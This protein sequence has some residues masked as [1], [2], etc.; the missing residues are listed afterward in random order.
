MKRMSTMVF[1]AIAL[2]TLPVGAESDD[3]T[4]IRGG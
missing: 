4:I 1:V 3:F 2:L